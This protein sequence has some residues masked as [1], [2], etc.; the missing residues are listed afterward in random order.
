[1]TGAFLPQPGWGGG[2]TLPQSLAHLCVARFLILK[3]TK[4]LGKYILG[5]LKLTCAENHDLFIDT[6]Y[7]KI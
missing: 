5:P 4:N 6:I 7:S 2:G 1:M 3:V